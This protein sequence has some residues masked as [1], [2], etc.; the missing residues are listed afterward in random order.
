MSDEP[1]AHICLYIHELSLEV[2]MDIVIKSADADLF[3]DLSECFT[4]LLA[5][6]QENISANPRPAPVERLH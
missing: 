3:T 6:V 2:H 5:Q 1:A 4:Q